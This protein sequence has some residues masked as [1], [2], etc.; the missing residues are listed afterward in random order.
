M[1]Y[2]YQF[3]PMFNIPNLSPFCLKVET[4]LKMSEL[5]HEVRY[6][7]DPR[8]GP[9]G[10]FPSI[11]DNGTVVPDST[12]IL[13]HLTK[14]YGVDLDA[15]LNDEERA[16]SHAFQ[17]M[18]EERLY[19][20]CVYNRWIDTNW[21]KTKK[22]AFGSL[23]PIIRDIV[24]AMV[25]KK[26]RRDLQGHG[27]GRHK[28]ETLY[29]FACSDIDALA[30]FLGDKPYFMGENMTTVDAVLY[31]FLCGI[32]RS[33]LDSPMNDRAQQ[34]QNLLEFETRIGQKYYPK[35]Y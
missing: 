13:S 12:L 33:G 1:I 29:E 10:K 17:R 2:L 30:K 14:Q 6:Q 27:I 25:Q 7:D 15:S 21:D 24:P 18:M 32:I 19:W 11:E 5:D 28:Q 4:W 31:G 9:L 8:K 20:A 35:Y 34:H 23:P 16:V 22:A 3:R 26:I